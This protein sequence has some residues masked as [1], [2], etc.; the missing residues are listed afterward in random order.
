MILFFL[1]NCLKT[2]FILRSPFPHKK[3]GIKKRSDVNER[4]F[5]IP[6]FLKTI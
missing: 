3:L 1:E 4:A 5:L 2:G 6:N